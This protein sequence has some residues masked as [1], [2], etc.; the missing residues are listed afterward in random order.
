MNY[1]FV[2]QNFPGQYRHVVR[3]LTSQPGNQ[4]YFLTQ[5]NENG[6][7]GVRKI[8]YPKDERGPINCHA[9][10]VELD[11]AIH[12]GATVADTCRHCASRVL[13]PISS[14]ATAAGAKRCS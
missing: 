2:H 6:M 4:V 14:S 1:L 9:Y 8:T 3:H 10:A 7:L 12:I 5:P 13:S 11:R